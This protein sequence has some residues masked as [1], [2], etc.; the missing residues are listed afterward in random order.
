SIYGA[1]PAIPGV[2]DPCTATKAQLQAAGYDPTI[3]GANFKFPN[4]E[5][6]T[7]FNNNIPALQPSVSNDLIYNG[8]WVDEL[9]TLPA[10]YTDTAWTLCAIAPQLNDSDVLAIR[11]LAQGQS[12]ERIIQ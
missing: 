9:L 3:N 12:P 8:L 6:T 4:G 7:L 2:T 1:V 10:K 5:R 11:V